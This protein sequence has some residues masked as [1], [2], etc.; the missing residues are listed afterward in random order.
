LGGEII[1]ADAFQV[2][3]GIPVL[4]SQPG[5]EACGG[6]PHHLVGFLDPAERFDAGRFVREARRLVGEIQARGKVPLVVG[7]T[8]LYLKALVEGLD[9]MPE[10]DEALRAE[11]SVMPLSQAV[12]ELQRL[13]PAGAEAVDLKNPARVRRAL[14]LVRQAGRPLAE[15][16]RGRPGGGMECAG[17]CLVR[18][19]EELRE[20]I[21]A[22][23]EAMLAGGAVDEVRQI[24]GQPCGG[25]ARAIGFREIGEFLAGRLTID[26][27]RESITTATR[28][29]AKRQLTWCRT[30]LNFQSIV[31]NGPNTPGS[32]LDAALRL[33]GR[34][35]A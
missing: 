11:I 32:A 2:Y 8:G 19:R 18:E 34:A 25:A 23:V 7:G 24:S 26:E 28:R 21:A 3:R 13:D 27:C 20:R 16:R 14:E 31:L 15:V 10:P 35:C 30:Q 29:Y 1:G 9:E 6:V 4:T 17:V 12:E 5:L 22:N 33:A